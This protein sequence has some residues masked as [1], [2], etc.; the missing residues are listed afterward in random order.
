MAFKLYLELGIRAEDETVLE[1]LQFPD[2][3]GLPKMD[4]SGISW[5]HG[6][7]RKLRLHRREEIISSVAREGTNEVEIE[8]RK[9]RST[10]SRSVSGV[11]IHL[12]ISPMNILWA[13]VP[14]Q[15]LRNAAEE[16][17]RRNHAIHE[18]I[19]A[20]SFSLPYPSVVEYLIEIEGSA[21][22]SNLENQRVAFN[23][24]RNAVTARMASLDVFGY[25]CINAD[26]RRALM[27]HNV[28]GRG[29]QIDKLG[30]KFDN[31]YPILIGPRTSCEGLADCLGIEA[32]PLASSQP[33]RS[34]ILEVPTHLAVRP[35]PRGPEV[36]AASAANPSV[37]NWLA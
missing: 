37:R 28:A 14:E 31:V 32:S 4:W 33:S 2:S 19:R 8:G 22:V 27:T 18:G 30:E 26:C 11:W 9:K 6:K 21:S 5:S 20:G 23:F 36:L 17:K 29:A 34:Y 25:A 10:S 24:I 13:P 35:G 7:T 16:R 1:L 3:E 15:S 12:T